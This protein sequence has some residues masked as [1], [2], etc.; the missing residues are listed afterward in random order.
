MNS[1]FAIATDIDLVTT[2]LQ[3]KADRIEVSNIPLSFPNRSGQHGQSFGCFL[4]CIMNVS[5]VFHTF[6]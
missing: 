3:I 1:A 6:F 2:A 5:V 4:T